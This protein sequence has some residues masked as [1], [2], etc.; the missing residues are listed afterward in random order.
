MELSGFAAVP[1]KLQ[2]SAYARGMGKAL[3]IVDI[4]N[5]FTEGGALG[6]NGGDRVAEEVTRYVDT[7]ADEY[8]AIIASRDWHDADSDNG[9]HFSQDPDFVD[10]WPVH[11]VADTEGAAYDPLLS[12]DAITDH[13][14]KGQGTPD[15]SAFQGTTEAGEHLGDLLT[16][17]TIAEVDVVGI[18]TDHCVRATVL[19]ALKGGWSVHVL[20]DLI[21]GVGPDSSTVAL[22]EMDAAGAT[23]A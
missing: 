22:S 7:H 2:A 15:Y 1:G 8:D 9:G 11:C 3:L 5:D 17:L 4:Q 18:A 10:T 20:Q 14:R 19:D 21:A 6:V 12:V 13:V 23:I 16:R